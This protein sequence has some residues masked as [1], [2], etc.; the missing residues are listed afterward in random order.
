MA[1]RR[2]DLE[3]QMISPIPRNLPL[4]TYSG[5]AQPAQQCWIAVNQI[6]RVYGQFLTKALVIEAETG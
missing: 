1:D 4:R 3:Q 2:F 5:L 6:E